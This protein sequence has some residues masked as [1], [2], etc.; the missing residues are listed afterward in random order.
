MDIRYGYAICGSIYLAVLELVDVLPVLGLAPHRLADQQTVLPQLRVELLVLALPP[1]VL[2]LTLH[3]RLV[4]AVGVEQ[5][6]L[7]PP[8]VIEDALI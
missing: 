3:S 7:L 6:A 5:L 1:L 8:E 4:V 2:G